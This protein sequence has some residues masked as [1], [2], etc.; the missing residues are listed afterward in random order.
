MTVS[1]WTYNESSVLTQEHYEIPFH[2]QATSNFKID[3]DM[4]ESYNI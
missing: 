2:N 4:K 1:P 3:D